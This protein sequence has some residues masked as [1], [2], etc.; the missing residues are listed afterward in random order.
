MVRSLAVLLLVTAPVAKARSAPL[1]I[2]EPVSPQAHVGLALTHLTTSVA[3]IDRPYIVYLSFYNVP[4]KELWDH[5]RYL[6]WWVH[7]LSFERAI[8]LPQ[9]VDGSDGRLV[10]VDLRSYSWNRRGW[11]AVARR[12]PFFREPWLFHRPAE[13]LR[14]AAGYEH[15]PP[16]KD[17]TTPAVVIVS[18][19]WFV[20]ETSESRRSTS[21]YDLLFAKW[22]FPDDGYTPRAAPAVKK[23]RKTRVIYWPGGDYTKHPDG[24]VR[25]NMPAGRYLEEYEE[26]E[27]A[28]APPAYQAEKKADNLDFPATVKDWEVAFGIDK[29]R[30]FARETR[31]DLDFGAIV[32]GGKDDPEKGSIVALQNRLLVIYPAPFGWAMRS[33]DVGETSGD[34]DYSETLIF[35]DGRFTKG[36]GADA[37][38]D[39]GELLAYLPAG[40]Q[41]GL[42]IDGKGKRLEV[43]GQ[44]FANDTANK[45]MNVGV[46]NYNSCI[47]CHA[48]GGGFIAPKD[49][50]DDDRKHGIKRKFKD[51][52]QALRYAAFFDEW[53]EESKA[54]TG[55]YERLIKKTTVHPRDRAAKAWDG[56]EVAKWT[57]TFRDR[58]DDAVTAERGARDL[59]VPLPVYKFLLSRSP[60]Q[61]LL[62]LLQ[63]KTIPSRTFEID[64]FK[65]TGFLLNVYRETPDFRRI[66]EGKR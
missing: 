26:D 23:V 7:Q 6:A 58:W 12:D 2:S 9:E 28:R 42:L 5:R 52:E 25:P 57:G 22:R 18:A 1:P 60:K 48:G 13:A 53:I 31:I 49:Q 3:E 34:R 14:E 39:A 66:S 54:S 45:R 4:G 29:L 20:R 65:Q 41:A 10:F 15:E 62:Q 21:Y 61:R 37:V 38:F 59:G 33:Y 56:S 8:S 19:S 47:T 27:T 50:E 30:A 32:A 43:A 46:T 36:D 17:G 63:G 44:L 24:K 35:K 11:E 55:R 16:A 51:K 64:I 40:G